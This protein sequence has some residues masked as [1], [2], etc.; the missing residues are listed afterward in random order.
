MGCINSETYSRIPLK[1]ALMGQNRCQ[2][3][4][5]SALSDGAYTDLSS[6]R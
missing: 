3:T 6:Y 5:Y 4:K 2:V 1:L